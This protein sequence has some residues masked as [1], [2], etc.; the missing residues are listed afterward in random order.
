MAWVICEFIN[1]LKPVSFVWLW[2]LFG[3][4]VIVV[5]GFNWERIRTA[6][7]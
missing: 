2:F 4:S 3:I 7:G 5:A 6:F 1:I